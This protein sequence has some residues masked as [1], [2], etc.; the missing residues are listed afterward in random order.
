[1]SPIHVHRDVSAMHPQATMKLAEDVVLGAE[2]LEKYA[3]LQL[4]SDRYELEQ[5]AI[6]EQ[7]LASDERA[8]PCARSRAKAPHFLRRPVVA[9]RNLAISSLLQLLLR[10]P[11]LRE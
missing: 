6:C 2:D 8:V 1:M 5:C 3:R 11:R 9:A 7:K 4:L 10:H